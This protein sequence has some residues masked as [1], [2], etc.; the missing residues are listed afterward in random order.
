MSELTRAQF[1]LLLSTF[2]WG[3][4]PIFVGMAL[5]SCTPLFIMMMRFAI[6]VLGLS[7]FLP[8]IKRR[9]GLI[10]LKNKTCILIGWLIS[11]GYL[12]STI[13]QSLTSAGL[14]TLIS[15]GYII[16][17][18]FMSWK[19]RNTSINKETIFLASTASL[20]MFFISFDGR[21]ENFS[22]IT[23]IGTIFLL[24]AAFSWGLNIV[25]SDK[26]MI[27]VKHQKGKF[28]YLSFLYATIVHTF[29]PLLFLSIF[30]APPQ[31]HI[32]LQIIPILLFLGVFST[33]VT[34]GLEQYALSV[35][36]DV[37]ITFYLILQ[38]PIPFIYEIFILNLYYSVWIIA[39]S[40]II[41][42]AMILLETHSLQ[43]IFSLFAHKP[44]QCRI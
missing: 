37:K 5:E 31:I 20:G 35:I 29:L 36:G 6:A 38:V 43:Y 39:G 19:L 8:E 34:F 21:W 32:F 11:A 30:E 1:S 42:V 27:D 17:V 40:V 2:I 25:V 23:N 13:G 18:P 24:V 9:K 41:L 14:A 28:D 16:M 7:V 15:T 10:F 22:N 3:L 44:E 12:T 4:A 26:F 33:I